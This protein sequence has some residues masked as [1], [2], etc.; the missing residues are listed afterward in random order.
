MSNFFVHESSY[1]DPGC[2]IGDSTKIWHFCHILSGAKIGSN[3]IIGQNVMVDRMVTIGNGCKIQNNNSIYNNVHL[4][5]EV[6]CGPSCT[7]TNVRFPRAFVER[8]KEFL[9]TLVKKGATIGANATI[10]CGVT[11]GKYC[12]IG[13]GAVVLHD[14]PAYACVVGNPAR[15]IHWQCQC[16]ESLSD[17]L[18][19]NRCNSQYRLN[20]SQQLEK[21]L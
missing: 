10:V 9:P 17:S 2:T 19:C 14:V 21:C 4:E 15:W 8:K 1:V 13:A 20:A 5:D 11:L 7:F 12:F 18:H 16:G 3:C 6:F